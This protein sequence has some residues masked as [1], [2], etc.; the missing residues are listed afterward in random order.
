MIRHMLAGIAAVAGLWTLGTGAANCAFAQEAPAAY[1]IVRNDSTSRVT[2]E[3]R[4]RDNWQQVQ[5]DSQKDANIT[6]DQIRVSTNREDHATITVTLPIQSGKKYRLFWNTQ[7]S[8][9]DLS[10]TID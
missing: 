5:I 1:S 7:S 4:S 2:I 8:M 10:G 9:W 6:G 3:Y